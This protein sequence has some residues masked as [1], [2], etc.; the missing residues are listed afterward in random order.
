MTPSFVIGCDVGSQGT[1]AALY[2]DDGELIESAY[3]AYDVAFPRPG[4]AE[5]DPDLWTGAVERACA[6]LVAVTPGGAAAVRGLSFGSQL[7]GMVVCD[8][9]GHPVRPAMIWMDRRAETQAAELAARLSPE[10]F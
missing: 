7:D 1:N 2:R 6:R 9:A 8:G 10:D 5:Q 3:E 4:W